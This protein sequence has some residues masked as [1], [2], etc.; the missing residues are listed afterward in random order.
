[1][2]SPVEKAKSF[3]KDGYVVLVP[4]DPGELTPH[5]LERGLHVATQKPDT[6]DKYQD[7]IKQSR[8][9]V[10]EK[11]LRCTYPDKGST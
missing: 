8:I 4:S 9:K 11:H 3:I 7:S 2:S 10:N 5:H 6:P 1:M